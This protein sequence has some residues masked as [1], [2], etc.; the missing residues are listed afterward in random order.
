[1]AN[2]EKDTKPKGPVEPKVRDLAKGEGS[3]LSDE[4]LDAAAGGRSVSL[5]NLM[6]CDGT[7]RNP[8]QSLIIVTKFKSTQVVNL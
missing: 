8:C 7:N 5:P 3:E 1:M 6:N 2:D 4:E